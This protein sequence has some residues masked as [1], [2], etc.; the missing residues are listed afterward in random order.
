MTTL[1]DNDTKEA[2]RVIALIGATL[3]AIAGTSVALDY[4]GLGW[5][6]EIIYRL[7]FWQGLALSAALWGAVIVLCLR[8]PRM[9]R[10]VVTLLRAI[11][12]AFM[13]ALGRFL[14]AA[15]G[16][17]ARAITAALTLLVALVRV[18]VAFAPIAALLTAIA[19]IAEP[20]RLG[21]WIIAEP[22]LGP[23]L[24]AMQSALPP[25]LAL[26][27]WLARWLALG[28][29]P[30]LWR[31]G[32]SPLIG[33]AMWLAQ[34]LQFEWKLW[35]TYR[36]EFRGAFPSYREFKSALNA[37]MYTDAQ[38]AQ[39]DAPPPPARDP[40]AAACETMGL[41]ADGNFTEA[42]FKARYRALMKK[43]HPDIA[44]PNARAVEVNA[45]HVLIK[46]RKGW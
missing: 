43:V 1:A 12:P 35:R 42:E 32:V 25:L 4:L 3:A 8:L 23:A 41:S 26:A 28:P 2:P 13:A 44:G 14:L 11:G 16:I 10:A 7:P 29:L 27:R 20:Y 15:P 31:H 34:T 18:G 19:Q 6:W 40:F 36:A 17:A 24:R 30:G 21:F 38:S 46:K 33:R 39:Q 37:R 45:A 9:I 22:A 5:V